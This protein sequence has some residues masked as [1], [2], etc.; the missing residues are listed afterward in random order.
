M[1]K[2]SF[3]YN[4]H[5]VTIE[6][7]SEH[8]TESFHVQIRDSKASDVRCFTIE[9]EHKLSI[10]CIMMQLMQLLDGIWTRRVGDIYLS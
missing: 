5:H 10:Y 9:N 6:S 3:R 7:V 8:E 4:G 2:T 1:F